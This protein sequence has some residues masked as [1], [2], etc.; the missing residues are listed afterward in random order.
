MSELNVKIRAFCER[1][2]RA[3]LF[4]EP[5]G[6][7][8]DVFSAKTLKLP[9]LAAAE[10]LKDPV[11]GATYLR[12]STDGPQLALTQAGIAFPPAFHNTGALEGLPG[13]VSFRDY[14]T[15]LDQLKHQLYGHPDVAPTRDTLKLILS[16]IAILDGARA[17]GF[18]VSREEPELETHLAELE[19]RAP[20]P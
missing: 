1:P 16:C 9:R 3:V 10:D 7:L 8:F 17:A 4:D 13:A 15:L 18:D 14:R 2:P 11:T 12:L 6:Q 20:P 19:R 5:A